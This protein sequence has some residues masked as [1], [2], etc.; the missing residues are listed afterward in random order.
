MANIDVLTMSASP[1]KRTHEGAMLGDSQTEEMN[2]VSPEKET[3]QPNPLQASITANSLTTDD[4]S[5]KADAMAPKKRKL[6]PAEKAEAQALREAEAKKKADEKAR[7]EEIKR[8]KEE[9]KR[10]K[11]E[12]KRQKDEEKRLRDEEKKQKQEEARRAKEEKQKAKD[13]EKA[14]KEAEKKA[15]EDAQAKKESV[16]SGF[17]PSTF[18]DKDRNKCVLVRSSSCQHSQQVQEILAGDPR[19][20]QLTLLYHKMTELVLRHQYQ[21]FPITRKHFLPSFSTRILH[22]HQR[23]CIPSMLT[24]RNGHKSKSRREIVLHCP[25]DQIRSLESVRERRT[26]HRSR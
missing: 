7:K 15:R 14:E 9:E 20:P 12:E 21:Q 25:L 19:L 2:T 26:D 22:W 8:Q 13:A 16:R 3:A 17:D 24:E 4:T 10:Q 5:Q 1:L 23:F 18:A 11:E 6:T